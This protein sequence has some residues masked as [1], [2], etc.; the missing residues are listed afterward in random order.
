MTRDK[1]KL[2]YEMSR[3]VTH[4]FLSD[5]LVNIRFAFL[6]FSDIQSATQIIE[7]ADQY[8]IDNQRLSIAYK[9]LK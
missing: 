2:G 3:S 5:Y 6:H 1:V 4:R 7:H 9:L 8:Y